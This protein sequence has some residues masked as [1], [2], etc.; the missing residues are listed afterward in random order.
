M[1][2]PLEARYDSN[3]SEPM[4]SSTLRQTPR[5]VSR[6]DHHALDD[7]LKTYVDDAG[8][9]DYE[10]L[11]NAGALAR[12]LASMA[13]IEPDELPGAERMAFWINAYNAWTL[14]L[15]VD[16]YPVESIKH[17][18]PFRVKGRSLYVPRFNSPWAY[19]VV[20]VGGRVLTLDYVEH[21]ILRRQYEDPRIHFALVCA[22]RS[23]PNLRREAYTGDRLDDQLE[24]QGRAFLQDARKNRIQ[25]D[26]LFLS[27]IFLWF[28]GDFP[29]G[30]KGLQG[31][32]APYFAA[33]HRSRLT[34]GAFSIRYNSYDWRLNDRAQVREKL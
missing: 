22:A 10:G 16:N 30:R 9:V 2:I 6:F 23:C 11:K 32:L 31:F 28:R 33:E 1:G 27:A 24:E 17:I 20:R 13:A 26:M 34:E 25:G 21:Q 7:V 3:A 14:Q 5:P 12:C 29:P 19:P 8:F 15:I 18:T 4:D